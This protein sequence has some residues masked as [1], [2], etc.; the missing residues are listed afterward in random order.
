MTAA[1]IRGLVL[2][3]GRSHRMGEDKAGLM[4]G[5]ATLLQRAF[6]LLS[7]RFTEVYVSVRADQSGDELRAAYP[8]IE[9]RYSELGPAAGI[10]SAHRFAPEVAWLV[11]GCDMPL[12]DDDLLAQLL[13]AR[14][15]E[16]EAI[17]CL[18]A[19][20]SGP[21]PLCALYEPATLAAL[22][23]HVEA[24]GSPSPRAWLESRPVTL[25]EAA[26]PDALAGA[27]TK[28]EFDRITE[29]MEFGRNEHD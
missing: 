14:V 21:E 25:I 8:L 10:L 28:Q 17:A 3:G 12:L 2:A 19:D 22:R 9:D 11:I 24:G 18:A 26:R 4:A 16:S 6:D 27:N 23:Q 20:G 13:A 15:A 7:A 29:Q 5:G 1:P